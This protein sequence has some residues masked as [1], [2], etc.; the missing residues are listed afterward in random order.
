M[1]IN[2]IKLLQMFKN[3]QIKEN[4]KIAMLFDGEKTST[5]LEYKFGQLVWEPGEFLVCQLWDDDFEFE[6]QEETTSR[7]NK[8]EIK[9]D[10]PNHFYLT[11]EFGTKCSL[12]KHS[13]MIAEKTNELIDKVNYLLEKEK[14]KNVKNKR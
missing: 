5:I 3:N 14:I 2:G 13:K 4:T 9:G 7:I 8:I 6:I 12:T 11:N 1:R 10:S